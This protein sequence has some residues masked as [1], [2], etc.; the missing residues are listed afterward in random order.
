MMTREEVAE[1][2]TSCKKNDIS[3]KARL[4]ERDIPTW[5]FYDSKSRY[6]LEQESSEAKGE[7]CKKQVFLQQQFS[8]KL[9]QQLSEKTVQHFWLFL[10]FKSNKGK[11]AVIVRITDEFGTLHH[12]RLLED[13]TDF[14]TMTVPD[15]DS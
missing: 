14:Q 2:I 9:F 6:A 7:S 3:Y 11:E 8:E 10:C 5:K 4:A 13:K 15:F 1:V 12:L